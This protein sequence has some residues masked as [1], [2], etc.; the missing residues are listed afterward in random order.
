[1]RATIIAVALLVSVI[2]CLAF[3]VLSGGIRI[4]AALLVSLALGLFMIA[5]LF[6][7][8]SAIGPKFRP[9]PVLTPIMAGTVV[10][11]LITVLVGV[12]G[13]QKPREQPATSSL[14]DRPLSSDLVPAEPPIVTTSPSAPLVS[15]PDGGTE[16]RPIR[17]LGPTP[18]GPAEDPVPDVSSE[19][20]P[21]LPLA[22]SGAVPV[23]AAPE[24]PAISPPN[25]TAT[26][27]GAATALPPGLTEPAPVNVPA[28]PSAE[29][30]AVTAP[31]PSAPAPPQNPAATTPSGP[32]VLIPTDL[33]G[34]P[35]ATPP[36]GTELA[37][38][39]PS[40]PPALSEPLALGTD[41]FDTSD[42]NALAPVSSTPTPPLP[43]SRP[44][45]V[46][47]LPCP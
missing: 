26:F 46:A 4:N 23:V 36:E 29:P 11:G 25:E 45:G 35:T 38:I 15:N 17:V 10:A 12:G 14:A 33:T 40:V 16:T 9:T 22:E 20:A 21:D 13:Q 37:P 30:A 1:M 8:I 44:C 19:P 41:T 39:D 47:G 28:S 3:L 31:G 7:A 5:V 24:E 18:G 27:D 2:L 43:R 6:A 34:A 32:I 42:P